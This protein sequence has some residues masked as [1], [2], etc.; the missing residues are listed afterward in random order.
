MPVGGFLFRRTSK[1]VPCTDIAGVE[2]QVTNASGGCPVLRSCLEAAVANG[3]V[4]A[5]D[6]AETPF[7]TAPDEPAIAI[8]F[9]CVYFAYFLFF[10][11]GTYLV[12]DALGQELT[13]DY[14]RREQLFALKGENPSSEP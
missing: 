3:T 13:R 5:S 1:S 4:F 12:Y 6:A 2:A 14:R 10:I 9:G 7:D 11:S 8:W